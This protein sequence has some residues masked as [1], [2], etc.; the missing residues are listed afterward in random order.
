[1]QGSVGRVWIAEFGVVNNTPPFPFC[2]IEWGFQN[3]HKR[4]CAIPLYF[5]LITYANLPSLLSIFGND[6]QFNCCSNGLE[7]PFKP[8]EEQ[9]LEGILTTM[10]Q[11]RIWDK[12]HTFIQGWLVGLIILEIHS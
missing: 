5:V 4:K 3:Y 6:F 9:Y 7:E 8:G 1:M 12:D 11:A 10:N 2:E